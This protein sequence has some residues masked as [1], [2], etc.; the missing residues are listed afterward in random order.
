MTND[1]GFTKA[2]F[3]TCLATP[4]SPLLPRPDNTNVALRA[5]PDIDL[6]VSSDPNLLWLQPEAIAQA[7]TSL[8]RGSMEMVLFEEA[9]GGPYYVAIK[10]ESRGGADFQFAAVF[11]DV[12][13]ATSETPGVEVLRGFPV[14]TVANPAIP[15]LSNRSSVFALGSTAGVTRRVVVSNMVSSECLGDL[16]LALT[17]QER[18]ATLQ[19]FSAAGPGVN[20]L[21]VYDD[22]L[23]A[24]LPWAQPSAGPGS[25]SLFAGNEAA[26][27][28]LLTMTTTNQAAT[29][30]SF[31]VHLE[32]QP[33][34]TPGT[35]RVVL[36]GACRDEFFTVPWLASNLTVTVNLLSNTGPVT[37]RFCPEVFVANQCHEVRLD[38]ERTNAVAVLDATSNPPLVP[39]QYRISL[40]N[41]GDQAVE[42]ELAAS[43]VVDTVAPA[44][45]VAVSKEVKPILDAAF[46]SVDL[47]V[48]NR[49]IISAVDVGVRIDH[50]R[51]S[52]L[53][54]ALRSPQGTRVLLCENRGA[55]ETN[56][57]GT[58]VL[59]TNI[60]PVSSSGGP[61]ATTN[62][63]DAGINKGILEIAYDF[64]NLPDFMRVY[65]EGVLLYDSG[66]VGGL[67]G[68]N[69]SFGPGASTQVTIVM[70]EGD[71]YDPDTA[72]DYTVSSTREEP[73]YLSFTENTNHATVPIK[74]ASPPFHLAEPGLFYLPEQSLKQL[75]G[76][77]AF[78]TW[79]LEIWDTQAEPDEP[80]AVLGWQVS[81]EFA[82]PSPVPITLTHD[83]AWA[84]QVSAGRI[85]WF[86]VDV[87]RWA[88]FATNTLVQASKPVSILHNPAQPPTSTN[89]GDVLILSN[90]DSGVVTLGTNS[91]PSMVPGEGY[92]VGIWNTNPV[93]V[94]VEFR[95][96]FDV[97][98]LQSGTA[99][100]AVSGPGP[101]YFAYD[102]GADATA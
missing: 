94:E 26:G 7:R 2:A 44:P 34:L 75:N 95:L 27:P 14:P 98:A 48:T 19:Q 32:H 25:L 13:F 10:C 86:R 15:G 79:K 8:G 42:V 64:Y 45:T 77:S 84:G 97:T 68:T 24:D 46:S 58:E 36:A 78:G 71:N 62:I 16:S 38:N 60:V 99:V 93:A 18:T 41:D 69:L 96:N 3:L 54:L 102:V 29:N 30:E 72:W 82:D 100:M 43:V 85:Q 74:F 47:V 50:P 81:F 21:S 80:A 76:E 51:I 33:E 53:V 59:L 11:T 91:L 89:V 17:H 90:A 6:Y 52:D 39:G 70:N 23:E 12:P 5:S 22:S 83:T 1:S 35:T 73:L 56:G 66:M 67:G 63:L 101:R 4:L 61:Q 31:S 65:Y 20:V 9:A 88:S 55:G 40:C 57:M 87:P 92:Y 49:G 28:W 37:I